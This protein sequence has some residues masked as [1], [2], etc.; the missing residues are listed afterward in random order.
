LFHGDPFPKINDARYLNVKEVAKFK[1]SSEL[2]SFK[3]P[4]YAAVTFQPSSSREQAEWVGLGEQ[5]H[6]DDGQQE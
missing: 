2:I 3:K 4:S 6:D 1:L 5:E